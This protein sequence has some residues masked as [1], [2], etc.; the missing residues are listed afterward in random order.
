MPNDSGLQ[1]VGCVDALGPTKDLIVILT[2]STGMQL[3]TE[4]L[5]VLENW[6]HADEWDVFML[7]LKLMPQDDPEALLFWVRCGPMM[8][9]CEIDIRE[10]VC[11]DPVADIF[12]DGKHQCR[13]TFYNKQGQVLLV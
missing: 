9:Y 7:K 5:E 1:L 4:D 11:E 13:Y 10:K 12:V 2:V 6:M 3:S 8:Q